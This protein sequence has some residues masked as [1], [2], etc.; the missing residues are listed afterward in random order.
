MPIQITKQ[1]QGYLL[2]ATTRLPRPID[3]VFRYFADARNLEALTP[4]SLRFEI[5]TPQPI[6]M[7]VGLL[8]DYR[9]RMHGVPVRWQSEITAWQPSVR[10]VDEQRRGPYRWWVHE[11][12]FE[13]IGDQT[14]VTDRVRYG[15]PGGAVV[16]RLL[17]KRDLVKIFTYRAEK[18][19]ETFG[20][21]PP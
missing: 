14:Q 6:E 7:R 2:E 4:R 5:L 19:H 8:I 17:V 9:L 16:H 15:V 11:H 10:F 12:R 3:E 20:V 13:T 1:N 21:S 18:L